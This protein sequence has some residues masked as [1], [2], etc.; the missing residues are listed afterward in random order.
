ME[1]SCND[2]N[3]GSTIENNEIDEDMMQEKD[4]TSANIEQ[5]VEGNEIQA[6]PF[7]IT[8]PPVRHGRNDQEKTV[9]C[10]LCT[11]TFFYESGLRTHMEHAHKKETDNDNEIHA[12]R[13]KRQQQVLLT[14]PKKKP[15]K[16]N[17]TKK[18]AQKF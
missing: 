18:E 16:R 12:E 17:T 9:H 11:E 10:T 13:L 7:T 14:I 5:R 1:Y 8:I 15:N 4:D 2:D 3:D 6:G